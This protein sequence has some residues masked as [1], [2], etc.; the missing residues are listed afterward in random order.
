[1]SGSSAK[2]AHASHHSTNKAAREGSSVSVGNRKNSSQTGASKATLSSYIRSSAQGKQLKQSAVGS[3]NQIGIGGHL[4]SQISKGHRSLASGAIGGN[5]FG[6][7][8]GAA[9][10]KHREANQNNQASTTLNL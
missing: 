7:M 2:I 3:R 10:P 8:G 6:S 5:H 4:N 1:M 9:E